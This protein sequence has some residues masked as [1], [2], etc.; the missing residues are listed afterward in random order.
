[1]RHSW[2]QSSTAVLLMAGLF[3]AGCGDNGSENWQFSERRGEQHSPAMPGENTQPDQGMKGSGPGAPL[4]QPSIPEEQR[5]D[6]KK[7]TQ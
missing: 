1:M 2:K 7:G 3:V 5:D 6:Q 4:P